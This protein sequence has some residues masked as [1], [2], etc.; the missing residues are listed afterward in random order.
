MWVR[1]SF[2]L[3]RDEVD[4]L[5]SER[6][7]ECVRLAETIEQARAFPS[8]AKEVMGALHFFGP[9]AVDGIAA[10]DSAGTVHCILP[11]AETDDSALHELLSA[12]IRIRKVTG[13]LGDVSR[14]VGGID[15]LHWSTQSYTL[16]RLRTGMAQPSHGAI[17]VSARSASRADARPLT[18]E[19]RDANDDDFKSLVALHR[20]YQREELRMDASLAETG[21]RIRALQEHQMVSIALLDGEPIGKINTN[22]R[23]IFCDQIGGFYIVPAR[24]R[25][26]VGARLMDH[27]ITRI[28]SEEKD[29]VLYLRR[30]NLTARRLYDRAGFLPVG[31]CAMSTVR[32]TH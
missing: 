8:L 11:R 13:Q 20:D 31:E 12:H 27:L 17:R 1:G 19:I 2:F 14:L 5:L 3:Y 4:R 26:G 6:E 18:I 28:R 15:A 25:M 22:A 7:H 16:M 21:Y 10:A 23:G 9:G 32:T 30:E 24:R 29:A